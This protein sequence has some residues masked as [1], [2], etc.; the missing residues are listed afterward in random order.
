[1]EKQTESGGAEAES[2]PKG[3]VWLFAAALGIYYA[4]YYVYFSLRVSE[5]FRDLLRHFSFFRKLF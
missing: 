5:Y 1:M 2:L 3:R 4:V